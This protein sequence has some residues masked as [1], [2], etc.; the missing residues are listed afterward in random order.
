M[1]MLGENDDFDFSNLQI[2]KHLCYF[3]LKS[4]Y[5]MQ[6]SSGCFSMVKLSLPK[7]NV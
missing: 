3:K 2:K 7:A 6:F 1:I 4:I 5:N